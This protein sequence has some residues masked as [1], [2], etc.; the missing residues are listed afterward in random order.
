MIDNGHLTPQYDFVYGPYEVRILD[1]V[2]TMNDDTLAND[3]HRLMKAF[4]MPK[5]QLQK[6]NALG[7][8]KQVD[9]NARLNV[10]HLD[11]QSLH[12]IHDFYSRDFALGD[13]AT[14]E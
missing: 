2:L 6:V 7:S 10:D 5:V 9:S 11:A 12:W 8:A 3:F 4:Q 14:R 1:Y 13:F